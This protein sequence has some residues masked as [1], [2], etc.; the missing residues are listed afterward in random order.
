MRQCWEGEE[1]GEDSSEGPSVGFFTCSEEADGN[2]SSRKMPAALLPRPQ[3][4]KASLPSHCAIFSPSPL[5]LLSLGDEGKG[6]RA[7]ESQRRRDTCRFHPRLPKPLRQ[8]L[9][10]FT[11]GV[12]AKETLGSTG[13]RLGWLVAWKIR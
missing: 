6:F 4:G 2:E 3:L 12:N 11:C 13:V 8:L 10:I 5:L 7:K 9:V 1:E